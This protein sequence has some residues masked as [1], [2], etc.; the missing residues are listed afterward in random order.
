LMAL[1]DR[2]GE[3]DVSSVR[4]VITGGAVVPPALVRQVEAAF[5]A[6]VSIVFAQTEASPVITQTA[7]DDS[8]EDRAE[9]LGRPLPHTEVKIT[10]DGELCTR[11]YHVMTGYFD[12]PDATAVAIDP[13]GWLHTGDLATVDARGYYRINGRLKDMIIRGGENIYPREVEL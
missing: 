6:R 3:C 1:L 4:C 12:N 11:G 2:L 7:P 8:D 5:D 9:T 10:R 13:D